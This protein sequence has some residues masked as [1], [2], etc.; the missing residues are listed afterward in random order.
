MPM[1]DFEKKALQQRIKDL[2]NE[3]AERESD[4]TRFRDELS[5]ANQRLESLIDRLNQ[6]LKLAQTLQKVLVPT[7]LPHIQG[8]EFSTKFVPSYV[9]GGDYFDIFEH[10]DRL[11][12]GLVMS[13]C[14]GYSTSALLMSVL[15][16][17]TGQ[18]EARRGAE[19][20]L[21]LEKILSELVPA[22][23][24]QSEA[25]LFYAMVDRRSFDLSYCLLGE[26]FA[27]HIPAGKQE[28]MLLESA[29]ESV[30]AGYGVKAQSKT[31]SL[32]PRDK[33]VFC[34]RGVIEVVNMNG[35]AFGFERLSQY[36]LEGSRL[37]VHELRNLIL[38]QAQKFGSG[39][40]PPRDQTV[41]VLEVKDRVIKLAKK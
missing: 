35:E 16:K 39:Q 26:V 12:F 28:L 41:M 23:P 10:E 3:V 34:T 13:S 18:M 19:P 30:S 24:P 40:E 20:H 31:L 7:D 6:E 2:E 33:L 36:L 37:G 9:K 32:N 25:D 38:Y 15:L 5:G 17:F 8:F 1:S 29:G 27:F 21:V 14:S 4:L 22:L 11:R